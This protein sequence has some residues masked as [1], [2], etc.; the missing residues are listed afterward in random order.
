LDLRLRQLVS[1]KYDD[2]YDDDDDDDTDD[3][4]EDDDENFR[5]HSH[6]P[7]V[8]GTSPFV[9]WLSGVPSQ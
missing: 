6:T 3:D 1:Y 4:E 2:D 9:G 8:C 5:L 7:T